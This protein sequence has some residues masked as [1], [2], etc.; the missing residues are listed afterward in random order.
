MSEMSD[1]QSAI[2]LVFRDGG[3]VLAELTLAAENNPG[4]ECAS[5]PNIVPEYILRERSLNVPCVSDTGD[6]DGSSPMM[7]Y[8]GGNAN[9]SPLLLLE[10]T[11]Y[12]ALHVLKEV[13]ISFHEAQKHVLMRCLL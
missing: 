8:L 2:V 9:L 12:E 13:G 10:E 3:R 6:I 1:L 7:I 5:M 4:S 11:D